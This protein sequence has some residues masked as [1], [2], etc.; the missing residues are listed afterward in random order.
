MAEKLTHVNAAGEAYMV[1]VAAKQPTHRTAVATGKIRMNEAAYLAVKENTASKGDVLAVA[2]VAGIMAAKKTAE[3]IPLC[4]P[5]ALS[6]VLIDFD[7]EE[8]PC[9]I[10]VQCTA[11]CFGVT[12]VEMEALCGVNAA[13]LTIYDMCKALDKRMWI[14]DVHLQS[15]TG[16]KSGDFYYD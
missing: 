7:C 16:G 12:G 1:H 4:H 6:N 9:C 10:Y 11:S 3:L 2:R 15:K 14:G 13:L 8:E 5:L